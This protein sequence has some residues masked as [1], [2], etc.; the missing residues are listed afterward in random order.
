MDCKKSLIRYCC[1]KCN[2]L[3]EKT[4]I[5]HSDK[6]NWCSIDSDKSS[7]DSNKPSIELKTTTNINDNDHR[8][9]YCMCELKNNLNI[10]L[11][12]GEIMHNEC[13]QQIISDG[14]YKCPRCSRSITCT[15]KIYDKIRNE[16]NHTMM[17]YELQKKVLVR[18][19][20]CQ[21]QMIADYN[22]VAIK[23][24]ACHGYNTYEIE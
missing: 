15:K 21:I 9:V 20:D 16:I 18:C 17:P 1:W 8:C 19:N 5:V 10:R 23:C 3:S 2:I 14:G 6:L 13:Y 12:C 7:I 4:D 11:S 22:I 24:T